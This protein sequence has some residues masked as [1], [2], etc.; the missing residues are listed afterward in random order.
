V[1]IRS[2]LDWLRCIL[3]IWER[4]LRN[5]GSSAGE[6]NRKVSSLL[7]ISLPPVP[8]LDKNYAVLLCVTVVEHCRDVSLVD[9]VLPERRLSS[10][11]CEGVNTGTSGPHSSDV[12]GCA[13]SL[14]V[15]GSGSVVRTGRSQG[16]FPVNCSNL[17]DPSS[18]TM[19]LESTQPGAEMT[20]AGLPLWLKGCLPLRRTGICEAIVWECEGLD[21]SLLYRSPLP[22][23]GS[24]AVDVGGWW[25]GGRYLLAPSR[26]RPYTIGLRSDVRSLCEALQCRDPHAVHLSATGSAPTGS[27][28]RYDTRSVSCGRCVHAAGRRGPANSC[29]SGRGAPDG[30]HAPSQDACARLPACWPA[31]L[32]AVCSQRFAP[33]HDLISPQGATLTF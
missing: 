29:R 23:T 10:R 28:A 2:I 12:N 14:C 25:R 7:Q 15:V 13:V 32:P 33:P 17:F 3:A 24:P 20:T 26:P 16:R 30:Q 18:R 11:C 31:G 4:S 27:S 19:A 5:Q 8:I 21:V 1:I 6:R 9:V 22:G